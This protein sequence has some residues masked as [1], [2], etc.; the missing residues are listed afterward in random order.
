MN[1]HIEEW[2]DVPSLPEWQASSLGRVRLK[3]F[4]QKMPNGGVRL[5]Q[6]K[7]LIGMLKHKGPRQRQ[8]FYRGLRS[9]GKNLRVHQMVCEAFHGPRPD[10]YI[11]MHLDEN[12]LNNRADNLAWGTR[13]ENHNAP[14]LKA[15]HSA[16]GRARTKGERVPTMREWEKARGHRADLLRAQGLLPARAS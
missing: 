14:K 16:T 1:S 15:Y 4:E 9:R 5:R 11:V 6:P 8:L 10:G 12:P 2:R 7:P 3:A 13:K